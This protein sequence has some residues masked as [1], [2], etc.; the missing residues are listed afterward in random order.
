MKYR[1]LFLSTLT[2]LLFCNCVTTGYKHATADFNTVTGDYNT[3]T[4]KFNTT[5]DNYNTATDDF[6]MVTVDYNT[7]AADYNMFTTDFNTVT[8]DFNKTD[9]NQQS[10]PNN[11]NKSKIT[12]SIIAYKLE[13]GERLRTLILTQNDLNGYGKHENEPTDN[14]YKEAFSEYEKQTKDT[15]DAIIKK[16]T[17]KD[18]KEFQKSFSSV[19][20]NDFID[21]FKRIGFFYKI[22][23]N[24]NTKEWYIELIGRSTTLKLCFGNKRTDGMSYAHYVG[25]YVKSWMDLNNVN[26]LDAVVRVYINDIDDVDIYEIFGLSLEDINGYVHK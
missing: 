5:T 17:E 1:L 4:T 15:L 10:I 12:G 24:K 8:T 21:I 9:F 26:D 18:K 23:Y 25:S 19:S 13:K 2:I 14:L 6:N 20:I 11:S 7:F 3:V 22:E 16:I